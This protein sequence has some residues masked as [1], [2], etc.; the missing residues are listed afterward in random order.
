MCGR[1]IL[2]APFSELV[3]LYGLT[4][5]VNLQPRY[6]IPPTEAVAV[7][8]SDP[9]GNGRCLDMLRW[10]LVPDWA[11]DKKSGYSLL[12][13]KAETV[14][15]NPSFREAFKKQRCIIP[16]RGIDEW[17]K[18][19]AKTKQPSAIVMRNRS[20]FGFAGLYSSLV[21]SML[22]G[23]PSHTCGLT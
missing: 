9:G 13:A 1:Y 21:S 22:R 18:I 5:S 12:N 10:G 19:D 14:A 4:N 11:T 3:R 6:N 16:A 8:R 15:E 23:I 20:I 7:V 2:K 17:R